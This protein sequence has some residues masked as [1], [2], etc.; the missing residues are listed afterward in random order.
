MSPLPASDD[1]RW[2]SGRRAERQ[3]RGDCSNIVRRKRWKAAQSIV[4]TSMISIAVGAIAGDDRLANGQALSAVLSWLRR[5]KTEMERLDRAGAGTH[6]DRDDPARRGRPTGMKPAGTTARTM[7]A[8]SNSMT[9]ERAATLEPAV[10]LP[11]RYARRRALMCGARCMLSA[12][13]LWRGRRDDRDLDAM[14]DG[15]SR[16]RRPIR[17]R[18]SRGRQSAA[19]CRAARPR[20]DAARA[21]FNASSLRVRRQPV[22]AAKVDERQDQERLPAATRSD[23]H[24]RMATAEPADKPLEVGQPAICPPAGEAEAAR[25]ATMLPRRHAERDRARRQVNEASVTVDAK[26]RDG[27]DAADDACIVPDASRARENN[28]DE[29]SRQAE[30]PARPRS[31]IP[32]QP[33][34]SGR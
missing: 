17:R 9:G 2:P 7:T 22:R 3:S 10:A 12:G 33:T 11:A 28:Q 5:L 30:G 29:R 26:R 21:T 15:A 8:R 1:G 24:D 32:G 16:E 13:P 20:T 34:A 6:R 31:A 23:D 18:R 25:R 4:P 14:I 19:C 27:E